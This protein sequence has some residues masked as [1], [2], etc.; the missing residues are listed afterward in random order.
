MNVE[1][2][3]NGIDFFFFLVK[4]KFIDINLFNTFFPTNGPDYGGTQIKVNIGIDQ[5]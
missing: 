4:L 2:S 3:N 1:I 5:T